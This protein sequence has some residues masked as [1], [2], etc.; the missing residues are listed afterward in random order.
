MIDTSA[1]TTPFPQKLNSMSTNASWAIFCVSEF[2]GLTLQ[3]D[4]ASI[5]VQP[6]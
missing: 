5:D 6:S 4:Y 2:A 1:G 3:R